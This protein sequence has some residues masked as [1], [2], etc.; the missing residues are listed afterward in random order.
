MYAIAL[1]TGPALATEPPADWVVRS[2]HF[3]LTD[4]KVA[5]GD[6]DRDG[7]TNLQEWQHGTD[8]V[9]QWTQT[10]IYSPNWPASEAANHWATRLNDRG[11]VLGHYNGASNRRFWLWSRNGSVKELP[12][13]PAG[14]ASGSSTGLNNWGQFVG[15]G[16]GYPPAGLFGGF[17]PQP[18]WSAWPPSLPANEKFWPMYINDLGQALGFRYVNGVW[19]GMQLLE[20]DGTVTTSLPA[21]YSPTGLNNYGEVLGTFVEPVLGVSGMFLSFNGDPPFPLAI[22]PSV[23]NP[24]DD[25]GIGLSRQSPNRINDHG[26]FGGTYQ[27]TNQDEVGFFYDGTFHSILPPGYQS[28]WFWTGV[29]DLNDAG[30][31]IG[32]FENEGVYGT[33]LW[34]QGVCAELNSLRSLPL[35]S[36]PIHPADINDAGEILAY[37]YTAPATERYLLLIPANDRDGDGMSDD[38]ETIHNLDPDSAA[39]ALVDSDGDGASNLTEYLLGKDPWLGDSGQGPTQGVDMR[40]GI[41][42]DGDGIPNTWEVANGFDPNWATDATMDYDHD[43]YSNLQEFTLGTNPLSVPLYDAHLIEPLETGGTVLVNDLATQRNDVAWV[44]GT[45]TGPAAGARPRA[46]AWKPV[47]ES[48]ESS[49][50]R[51][52]E[53]PVNYDLASVRTGALA[54][55]PDGTIYGYVTSSAS[56][57]YLPVVWSAANPSGPGTVLDLGVGPQTSQFDVL[58]AGADGAVVFRHYS[59]S[60]GVWSRGPNAASF[61]RLS[62][63][64]YASVSNL[65]AGPKGQVAVSLYLNNQ[66]GMALWQA[67]GTQGKADPASALY[68]SA[69]PAPS[70]AGFTHGY[71]PSGPG[72]FPDGS[73]LV[74]YASGQVTPGVWTYGSFRWPVPAPLAGRPQTDHF[75]LPSGASNSTYAGM[76]NSLGEAAGSCSVGGMSRIAFWRALDANGL[77]RVHVADPFGTSSDSATALN[78]VGEILGHSYASGTTAPVLWSRNK[79]GRHTGRSLNSL[80]RPGADTWVTS[81]QRLNENGDIVASGHRAGKYGA[82]LLAPSADTDGDGMADGWEISHGLNAV[83]PLDAPLDA[84]GDTIDNLT[85]FR[86][87]SNPRATDSDGDAMPD[88]WEWVH[89]LN[90]GSASDKF[91]DP[92]GDYLPNS[93]EWEI[94]GVNGHVSLPAGRWQVVMSS[95]PRPLADPALPMTGDVSVV[96]NHNGSVLISHK[97]ETGTPTYGAWLWM[98]PTGGGSG[99]AFLSLP[100]LSSTDRGAIPLMIQNDG[101][102]IGFSVNSSGIRTPVRWVPDSSAA[103]M[104]TSHLPPGFFRCQSIA[105]S[106]DAAWFTGYNSSYQTVTSLC[107]NGQF[108]SL[109]PLPSEVTATNGIPTVSWAAMSDLVELPSGAIGM[110]LAAAVMRPVAGV[111]QRCV[112]RATLVVSPEGTLSWGDFSFS[113]HPGTPSLSVTQVTPSGLVSYATSG[114]S[115]GRWVV[116]P[117]SNRRWPMPRTGPDQPARPVIADSGGPLWSPFSAV[118]DSAVGGPGISLRDGAVRLNAPAVLAQCSGMAPGFTFE[119]FGALTHSFG[120]GTIPLAAGIVRVGD[121]RFPCILRPVGSTPQAADSDYAQWVLS[122]GATLVPFEDEDGDGLSNFREYL[123]GSNPFLADSNGDGVSDLTEASLG[124]ST[125]SSGAGAALADDDGDGLTTLQEMALGTDPTLEDSDGDGFADADEAVPNNPHF[126]FNRTPERNYVRIDIE[127]ES[128]VQIVGMTDN[129][130]IAFNAV[131]ADEKRPGVWEAGQFT[132]LPELLEDW[133]AEAVDISAFQGGS[134]LLS[135]TRGVDA[136]GYEHAARFARWS[137][138]NGWSQTTAASIKTSG[139]NH[140]KANA[141]NQ[142]H[143]TD[144]LP[145]QTR[146]LGQDPRFILDNGSVFGAEAGRANTPGGTGGQSLSIWGASVPDNFAYA[147]PLGGWNEHDLVVQHTQLHPLFETFNVGGWQSNHLG[148]SWFDAYAHHPTGNTLLK[149]TTNVNGTTSDDG[150]FLANLSQNSD[151]L[152]LP[153]TEA[154]FTGLNGWLRETGSDPQQRIHGPLLARHDKLATW[155]GAGKLATHPVKPATWPAPGPVVSVIPGSDG[156]ESLVLFQAA[157]SPTFCLWRN[158]QIYDLQQNPPTVVQRPPER[159][160]EKVSTPR[161]ILTSS[162]N[163]LCWEEWNGRTGGAQLLLPFELLTRNPDSGRV[164]QSEGVVAPSSPRPKV[165]M[166]LVSAELTN[167]GL[168][169]T[170]QGTALD[171]LSE[172][173]ANGGDRVQQLHFTAN[174]EALGSINLDYGQGQEPWT[175]ADSLTE[176]EE[177]FTIPNPRPG[178]YIIKAETDANAAGNAGWDKV[179]VGLDLEVDNDNAPAG[180]NE[181]SIALTG[182]ISSTQADTATVYFG[183]RVP[184]AGDGTMTETGADTLSFT[185]NIIVSG[186]SASCTVSMRDPGAFTGAQDYI[187]ADVRYTIQGVEQVIVGSWEETG[188]NSMRFYPDGY[189]IGGERLVVN[190]TM[191]IPGSQK[192]SFEPLMMKVGAP[193][194]WTQAEGFK[195]T[196]N[197]VEHTLKKFTFE[198]QEGMYVVKTSGDDRPKIFIPSLA[199]LP[200]EHEIT[201]ASQGGGT[202]EWVMELGGEEHTIAS[203]LVVAGAEDEFAQQGF[204]APMGMMAMGAP[205]PQSSQQ[206]SSGGWQQPG[207][208]ITWDDLITAYKFIY[209]DELS[210]LLLETYL[211]EGHVISLQDQLGDYKFEY[212]LRLDG[213]I[214]I[215]IE[216]DDSDMHPGIAA[217]YL[218]MGLNKAL[219]VY[220]YRRAVEDAAPNADLEIAAMNAWRAQVG[221]A[222][223]EAGVAAAEFYLAGIGIVNEPLDWVLVVDDLS[224]GH[225]TSIAAALPFIPRGLIAGGRAL[226]IKNAA[227]ETLETFSDAAKLDAVK[228]LYRESDLRVMGVT[229]EQEQFSA[230]MRKAMASGG[231]PVP[232]PTDREGLRNAMRRSG[233]QPA[234]N[235]VRAHHD[236]PWAERVW[237]ASRGIDVNNPAFGRWVSEIDHKLWHERA[238]PKFNDYWKNVRQLERDR[239]AG[240]GAPFSMDEI[241]QKLSECRSHYPVTTGN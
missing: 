222:A 25:D 13:T 196:V 212:W 202:I 157:G 15:Q 103:Y 172:A 83:D 128:E 210:Q 148:G 154:A 59:V 194:E 144:N 112:L 132:M 125:H 6:F 183:N 110:H 189:Q 159:D 227:G 206:S 88:Q 174:G 126:T 235:N 229:M 115:V 158:G 136:L 39:D 35:G 177:T 180:P 127:F 124:L 116:D 165:K 76:V 221:P 86:L 241:L 145:N 102:I 152:Q 34:R 61:T 162:G 89:G 236:F 104:V 64:S 197:G 120:P 114:S 166:E 156:G 41:D 91:Q 54:V 191:D 38:W 228:S 215:K 129:C 169:I 37:D 200:T 5:A 167:N 198:G 44:V 168:E 108:R 56:Y 16:P 173:M 142:W 204:A 100:K 123:Q 188:G 184:Q 62:Q 26:E 67:N 78:T 193:E 74:T 139:A 109:P 77:A 82:L 21:G 130:Q 63:L 131:T 28:G 106:R 231:G 164:E 195:I 29:G 40:P 153:S 24:D 53:P 55:A 226:K 219:T 186:Q 70:P 81:A 51:L 66:G 92:D 111:T 58:E 72:H 96:D 94:D 211:A 203:T 57:G 60:G 65:N 30:Q 209:P 46:F 50:I 160:P 190:S 178:S 71:L 19:Q 27:A 52:L 192:N 85:E 121:S 138:G 42:S 181:L 43:G 4:P 199:T 161:G 47:N 141:L 95:Y 101:S 2:V 187:E 217:Q 84:D 146:S 230:F 155:N 11:E 97:D 213:K 20:A 119:S 232:V 163:I 171:R 122:Q 8:P 237:F 118:M 32:G 175:K 182:G 223:A 150:Y 117:A 214:A 12:L 201:G 218:W 135:L 10:P 216:N 33:F 143:V 207:D 233:P 80:L 99:G 208:T 176:F 151:P 93:Q 90:P 105:P 107:I 3:H 149:R 137:R 234:L 14:V 87:G 220:T 45:Y 73:V 48:G 69:A 170:V 140:Y 98:P 224:E 147:V 18:T 134:V 238:V 1:G 205:E 22:P 225:Y 23:Y 240:G 113:P 79:L 75:P 31:I 239:I 7:V 36:Y 49:P 179:A 68:L 17:H 185:G 9:G 133:R